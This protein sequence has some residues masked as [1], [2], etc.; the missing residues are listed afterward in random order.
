M[1][2]ILIITALFITACQNLAGQEGISIP[3]KGGAAQ[4]DK[5][6]RD[7]MLIDM[8]DSGRIYFVEVTCGKKAKEPAFLF[9]GMEE[10][11]A[12][13][14]LVR[15]FFKNT[16]L[17]W[18]V[19][20]LQKNSIV[21]PFFI[22]PGETENPAAHQLINLEKYAMLISKT[23]KGKPCLLYKPVYEFRQ[24]TQIDIEPNGTE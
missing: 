19:K 22:C 4:F 13:A 2:S 18:D 10:N 23:F 9:H 17:N 8:G 16:A 20:A 21:I 6:I 3:Y 7:L 14:T 5:D 12:T 11:D 15:A 1:K 24:A